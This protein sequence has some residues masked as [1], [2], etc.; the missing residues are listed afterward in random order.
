MI[1]LNTLRGYED[2]SGPCA[3]DIIEDAIACRFS[4]LAGYHGGS[5]EI[6]LDSQAPNSN[7]LRL[8]FHLCPGHC[9]R[10]ASAQCD[11]VRH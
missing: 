2:F 7:F 3:R 11:Y 4:Y 1:G 9:I 5:K 10:H 8:G 6:D